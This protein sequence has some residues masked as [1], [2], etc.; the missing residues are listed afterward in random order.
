M[1]TTLKIS[2]PRELLAYLPHHLGFQPHN[3]LVIVCVRGTGREVGLVLRVDIA[4]IAHPDAGAYQIDHI[5]EH[6][7][8]DGASEIF[9][10]LYCTEHDLENSQSQAR[11]AYTMFTALTSNRINVLDAWAVTDQY[12][13]SLTCDENCCVEPQLVTDFAG[14]A[15]AAAAVYA[16]SHVATSREELA[17]IALA[18]KSQRDRAQRAT[19]RWVAR[20]NSQGER[21]WQIDSWQEWE[22]TLRAVMNTATVNEA[23]SA[24]SLSFNEGIDEILNDP[25]LLGRLQA[26]LEDYRVR[27]AVMISAIPGEGDLPTRSVL[28]DAREEVGRSVDKILDPTSAVGPGFETHVVERVLKA[29]AAHSSQRR[30]APVL[31]LMGWISWWQGAGARAAV[32]IERALDTDPTHNMARLVARVLDLGIPPGWVAQQR[33]RGEVG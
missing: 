25:L 10:A 1:T 4:D 8:F 20:R 28:Q 18:P 7:G 12:F 30:M 2:E 32:L 21:S 6:I 27:D 22:E 26:G 14:A 19:H 23:S 31:T 9:L 33:R 17:N 24:Q 3:S 29:V 13:F 16:G 15:T 11:I 5:I